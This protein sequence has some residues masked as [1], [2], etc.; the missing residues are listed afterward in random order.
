M[1]PDE[2]VDKL[3]LQESPVKLMLLSFQVKCE[4]WNKPEQ[5]FF[6]RFS[7]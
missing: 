2:N 3:P 7:L 1:K 6:T 4:K 5:V